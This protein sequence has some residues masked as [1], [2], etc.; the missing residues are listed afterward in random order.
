MTPLSKRQLFL[1]FLAF[2]LLGALYSVPSKDE[3]GALDYFYTYFCSVHRPRSKHKPM[4]TVE[5]KVKMDCDGCV[6]KVKNAVTYMKG[7][8]T[9]DVNQKQS[10]VTVTGHVDPNKVLKRVKRTGKR[11]EFWTYVPYNLVYYPHSSQAYDKRAP[12]GYVKNTAQAFPGYNPDEA[13]TSLFSEDNP[14]ACSIM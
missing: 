6:R 5:L 9:V 10:R 14:H 11:A 8:K 12:P 4:Q 7:V 3:M 13:I 2:L 1:L